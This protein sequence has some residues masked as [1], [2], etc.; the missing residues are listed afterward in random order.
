MKENTYIMEENSHIGVVC[1]IANN[2]TIA[3]YDERGLIFLF[4]KTTDCTDFKIGDVVI[5]NTFLFSKHAN[6]EMPDKYVY[7]ITDP[8]FRILTTYDAGYAYYGPYYLIYGGYCKSHAQDGKKD[9]RN[10]PFT[11]T[12]KETLL[13]KKLLNKENIEFIDEQLVKSIYSNIETYI[14]GLDISEIYNSL[15]IE[16]YETHLNRLGE[17]DSY[18]VWKSTSIKTADPYLKSL[19]SIGDELLYS[20]TAFNSWRQLKAESGYKDSDFGIQKKEIKRAIEKAAKQYS[21]SNHHS[22][23]LALKLQEI[24]KHR[25]HNF[26]LDLQLMQHW[27]TQRYVEMLPCQDTELINFSTQFDNIISCLNNKKIFSKYDSAKY[28][29][30]TI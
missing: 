2:A 6:T 13:V 17:D 3:I 14:K 22:T 1:Q 11:T 8:T 10:S 20:E 27:P 18:Y 23:L 4:D 29:E 26:D 25:Q 21:Y 12:E 15:K 28:N 24:E 19:F 7:H 30:L 9:S 16:I 5:F